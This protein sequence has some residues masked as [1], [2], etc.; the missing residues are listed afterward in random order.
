METREKRVPLIF[1]TK[2]HA[3]KQV[4]AINSHCHRGRDN[5]GAVSR[6]HS[7]K[8]NKLLGIPSN[9]PS[10]TLC[11]GRNYINRGAHAGVGVGAA[12]GDYNQVRSKDVGSWVLG[13][14]THLPHRT[15][16]GRQVD[17][18]GC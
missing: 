4:L 6:K 17:P 13:R 10:T 7:P 12:P 14:Q 8:W 9:N 5:D 3:E 1:V 15:T 11:D 18:V 2:K 16:P